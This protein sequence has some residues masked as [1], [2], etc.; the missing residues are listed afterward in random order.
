MPL[1]PRL[2]LPIPLGTDPAT[3]PTDL[4]EFATA[5]ESGTYAEGLTVDRPVAEKKG[6][7]Y[8]ATDTGIWWGDTGTGVGAGRWPPRRTTRMERVRSAPGRAVRPVAP[9]VG[10][11]GRFRAGGVRR[12]RRVAKRR[13]PGVHGRG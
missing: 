13:R 10:D 1:T 12:G 2:G 4:N 9:R 11:A 6:R 5:L 8:R 7:L 3:V